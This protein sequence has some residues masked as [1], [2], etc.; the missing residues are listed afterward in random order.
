[1]SHAARNVGLVAA[2]V[3]L[4]GAAP[5]MAQQPAAMDN[6]L[7]GHLG[8]S[9]GLNDWTP[10]GFKM[11]NEYARKVNRVVWFD[12]QFNFIAGGDGWCGPYYNRYRCVDT[13]AG[14]AIEL[15]AGVKLKF[16]RGRLLPY[17]KLGGGLT[18]SWF[19]SE[20]A[21]TALVFRG[22]GGVKY[23]VIPRLA[24]GGELVVSLGPYF[25]R[26]WTGGGTRFW[27][28]LDV[29]GGVEFVF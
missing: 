7:S 10:G 16:P 11:A 15:I 2:A 23:F 3:V 1:M 18:L 5:A 4:L 29:L 19:F 12:A 20:H 6:E 8:A 17:A 9:I 21:G 24:V 26:D 22:G 13:T 28:G 25:M 27:A 14:N